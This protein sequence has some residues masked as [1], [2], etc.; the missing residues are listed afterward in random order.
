MLCLYCTKT[1]CGQEYSLA[2]RSSK[3][4]YTHTSDLFCHVQLGMLVSEPQ[5]C[6]LISGGKSHIG[7]RALKSGTFSKVLR[8][9]VSPGIPEC[10]TY[11]KMVAQETV[12][13]YLGKKQPENFKYVKIP[14]SPTPR[15]LRIF[16]WFPLAVPR[17][18]LGQNRVSF[19]GRALPVSS[20]LA[21]PL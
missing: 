20:C 15:S 17:V 9:Y 5:F 19:F 12:N 3:V 2:S 6:T 21:K 13:I 16:F 11:R 4:F 7:T 8:S 1:C 10:H 14:S 18:R